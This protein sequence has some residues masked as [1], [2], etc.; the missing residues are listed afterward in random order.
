MGIKMVLHD[1]KGSFIAC[2]CLTLSGIY[3]VELGEA[4]RVYEVLSWIKNI[5]LMNIVV[6][7]DAKMVFGELACPSKSRSVLGNVIDSCNLMLGNFSY[8][9]FSL[10][11]RKTNFIAHRIATIA[12][13]F[14]IPYSWV[15]PPS[16]VESLPNSRCSCQ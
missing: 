6:E 12:M 10:V 14:P 9:D 5:G 15:E 2:R 3:A 8:G 13:S 11:N 1:D 4:F 7:M 16:F